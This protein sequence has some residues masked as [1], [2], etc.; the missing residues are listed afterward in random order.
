MNIEHQRN[1]VCFFIFFFYLLWFGK[2]SAFVGIFESFSMAIVNIVC[3]RRLSFV[4]PKKEEDK[5]EIYIYNRVHSMFLPMPIHAHYHTQNSLVFCI[6]LISFVCSFIQTRFY[7]ISICTQT[8]NVKKLYP[9]F[10][11]LIDDDLK[12]AHSRFTRSMAAR[13][14]CARGV[15][16]DVYCSS[17]S[18]N[19]SGS[20][21]THTHRSKRLA[22]ELDGRIVSG[23]IE[24]SIKSNTFMEYHLIVFFFI[25]FSVYFYLYFPSD[26]AI[27]FVYLYSISAC[28]LHSHEGTQFISFVFVGFFFLLLSWFFDRIDLIFWW[29]HVANADFMPSFYSLFPNRSIDRSTCRVHFGKW[30]GF[31]WMCMRIK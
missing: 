17:N 20:L 13:F 3:K 25:R 30:I 6:I 12:D 26:P 9:I 11:Y 28:R 15:L 8:Y 10:F 22:L 24:K 18:S 16:F 7:S 19:S 21:H 23:T 4:W 14:W 5:I 1:F 2:V 31:F 29:S 27:H